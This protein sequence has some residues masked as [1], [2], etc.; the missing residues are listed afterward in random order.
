[1]KDNVKKMVGTAIFSAI[2]IVLTLISNYIPIAGI[3]INL[4]LIAIA[5]SAIIYGPLSG[6]IV[7]LVN[8]GFV[9]LAAGPFFAISPIGTVLVCLLKSGLAGLIS[10]YVYLLFKNKN[11][12]VASILAA[13]VVP[14]INTALFIVGSLIFFEGL[15]G[16]L[17][18]IFISVNFIIE[19]VICLLVSPSIKKVVDV[20]EKRYAIKEKQDDINM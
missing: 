13:I 12:L 20:Y 14:I 11:K 1:M 5:T 3:T 17:I 2:C 9:M 19:F 6:L 16:Q 18:S 8:G 15:F 7:G 4:A 10:G